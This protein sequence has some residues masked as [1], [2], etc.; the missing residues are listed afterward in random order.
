MTSAWEIAIK[1]AAGKLDMIEDFRR[2]YPVL[3]A[4]N[5]FDLLNVR[6]AHAIEAAYLSGEHRDPFDR[7][8]AAQALT[9]D[10]A[11]ITR[12]PELAAFG[13]RTIW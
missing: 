4:G 7:L 9:E 11:V 6:D 8:L 5:G 2:D 1:S 13:C 12:D 3:M 10:L